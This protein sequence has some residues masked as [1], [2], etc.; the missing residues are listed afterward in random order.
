MPKKTAYD[1]ELEAEAKRLR[2][3]EMVAKFKAQTDEER[4]VG[5]VLSDHTVEQPVEE[6]K[7]KR[8]E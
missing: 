4:P 7:P 6:E 3:A 2:F 8:K 5:P 1:R